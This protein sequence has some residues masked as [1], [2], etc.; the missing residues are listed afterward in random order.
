M[1]LAVIA[2][3]AGVAA[4]RFTASGQRARA[5]L[6][7]ARVL[8]EFE[9]V[10][11]EARAA[12]AVRRIV[13]EPTEARLIV[14][15]AEARATRKEPVRAVAFGAE[16]Y[17]ADALLVTA[18][19]AFDDRGGFACDGWGRFSGVGAA[20]AFSGPWA[21]YAAWD[22]TGQTLRRGLIRLTPRDLR[23]AGLSVTS[24]TPPAE[25]TVRAFVEALP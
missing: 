3:L 23:D 5:D 1:S 4:P 21:G 15:D 12:A 25:A 20:L 8:A 11:R 18:D 17:N 19:A 9:L 10:R 14:L 13:I 2:I 16:P 7:A 24:A 22:D 6:A